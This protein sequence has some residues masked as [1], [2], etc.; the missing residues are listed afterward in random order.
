M[1]QGG[2]SSQGEDPSTASSSRVRVTLTHYT[3]AVSDRCHILV[4]PLVRHKLWQSWQAEQ[5]SE[6][7]RNACQEVRWIEL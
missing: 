6:K 4:T 1:L 5:L 2:R 7:C 3:S